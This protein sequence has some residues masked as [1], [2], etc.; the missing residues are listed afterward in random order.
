MLK[1][2]ENKTHW[3]KIF[4]K[5]ISDKGLVSKLYK[6]TPQNPLK[7][8]NKKTNNPIRKCTKDLNRNL[9]RE[10]IQMSNTD[11]KRCLTSYVIRK[12]QTKTRYTTTYLLEWLKSKTLT[13]PNAGKKCKETGSLI[14]CWWEHSHSGWQFG[15]FL[16]VNHVNTI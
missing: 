4:A 13:T 15:S 10:D 11:V 14:H 9:P 3:E 8:Q 2:W 12:L 16:K 1:E 5:H 6:K 7:M